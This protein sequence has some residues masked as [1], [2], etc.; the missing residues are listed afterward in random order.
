MRL[1]ALMA[2]FAIII[3]LGEDYYLYCNHPMYDY[4]GASMMDFDS[5]Y[6]ILSDHPPEDSNIQACMV[7]IPDKT[8]YYLVSYNFRDSLPEKYGLTGDRV[9]M[10]DTSMVPF[11]ILGVALC[12]FAGYWISSMDCHK[13]D[14]K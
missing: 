8:D 6:V 10:F 7:P 11:F 3:I 4:K 2:I 1:A 5:A 13:G 12:A 9:P 14:A